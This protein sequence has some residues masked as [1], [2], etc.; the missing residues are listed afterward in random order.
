MISLLVYYNSLI[1]L[2]AILI[3]SSFI[4]II[5]TAFQN[6]TP[7]GVE[8]V[9]FIYSLVIMIMSYGSLL[10]QFCLNGD[11]HVRRARMVWTIERVLAAQT[12]ACLL[13]SIAVTYR[14]SFLLY[15]I[16]SVIAFL[17]SWQATVFAGLGRFLFP[18]HPSLKFEDA[19]KF[20]EDDKPLPELEEQ[21]KP[22]EMKPIPRLITP[23]PRIPEAALSRCDLNMV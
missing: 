9:Q 4:I 14:A 13:N 15:Q 20:V 10:Y 11:P 1:L 18:R 7:P 22:V 5:P 16:T 3:S 6:K 23:L 8:I 12:L 17:L 2:N 19:K 21:N